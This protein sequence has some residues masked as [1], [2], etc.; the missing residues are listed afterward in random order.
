VPACDDEYDDDKI[1]YGYGFACWGDEK[2]LGK[3][4]L[5]RIQR[6]QMRG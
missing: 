5:N 4:F 2:G 1:D 3:H 6:T